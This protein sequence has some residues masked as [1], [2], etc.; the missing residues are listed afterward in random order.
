MRLTLDAGDIRFAAKLFQRSLDRVSVR[1]PRPWPFA[2]HDFA[3]QLSV[4]EELVHYLATPGSS[5]TPPTRCREPDLGAK[6]MPSDRARP[7]AVVA[8]PVQ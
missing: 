6:T 3:I 1:L 7:A 5:T 2:D 4:D 8:G